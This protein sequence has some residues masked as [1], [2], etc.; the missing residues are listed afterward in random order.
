MGFLSNLFSSNNGGEIEHLKKLIENY[1]KN[2]IN[3]KMNMKRYKDARAPNH[4]QIGGRQKINHFKWLVN[5]CKDDIA[6]LK[7]K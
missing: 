7:R 4:Y 1:K 5:N 3:E 6:R 2:I